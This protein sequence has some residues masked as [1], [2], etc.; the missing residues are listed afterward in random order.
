L[1]SACFYMEFSKSYKKTKR[2][3]RKKRSNGKGLQSSGPTYNLS[4]Y[5]GPVRSPK[6]PHE[7]SVALT[8][9]SQDEFGTAASPVITTNGML[10]YLN[11]NPLY[12]AQ[13]FQIYRY[14]KI[15]AFEVEI[16]V[17]NKGTNPI[18]VVVGSCPQVEVSTMTAA[19]LAEKTTSVKKIV[20]S[21]GGLDRCRIRKF[22]NN[23]AILG[24]P[25]TSKYWMSYSQSL[26]TTPIDVNEPVL[27]VLLAFAGGST[28]ISA[29]LN[30]R[31][32]YHC[33]FFEL[34]T[35]NVS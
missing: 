13:L 1:N 3:G 14:C 25:F 4:A 7:L 15:T 27:A 5:T 6:M 33:Q 21:A 16:D 11:H 9:A 22:F 20:S 30:Y 26:S 28:T 18:E 10:E 24:E 8:Y 17:F 23:M 2:N 35:P 34:L 29:V 31:Y 32:K 19:R 12:S